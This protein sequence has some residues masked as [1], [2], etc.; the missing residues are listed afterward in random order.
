MHPQS[1]DYII[2]GGG[3]AGCATAGGLV[4]SDTGTVAVLEAG[5][6]DASPMV[7]TP[8]AL[9]FMM[10][11]TKR[12]WGLES[13][14]QEALGGRCVTVPRGKM[15]GGSGSINSMVWFRGRMDDFDRWNVPGWSAADVSPVFDK[16]EALMRPK[17]L[18]HPH[19]LAERFARVFSE[20]GELPPTPERES[21][22]IFHTNMRGSRRWSP[23]DAFLNPAKSS[24]RLTVKTRK[25]VARILFEGQRAIAVELIDGSKI[26]A[27][28]GI[29]LCAGAL[30]SPAILMRSG[31]GPAKDLYPLGID[32]LM[33]APQVGQNLHDHPAVG[34]HHAGPNSGYGLTLRQLPMWLLAPFAFML[35]GKG[36]FAS[37]IVEA[38][39]FFNARGENGPPDVQVHFIPYMM[40]WKGRNPVIG[41]GYFADVNVL[42]PKSRGTLK[43]LSADPASAPRIDL[44]VLSDPE[45]MNTLVAAFKRLREIL[46]I[47]PFSEMRAP[48]VY[49]A[50]NAVTDEQIRA[51]IRET[52]GTSYHPVG[53]LRMGEGEAP[54]SP[55]LRLKGMENLWIADASVMPRITSANIN[56]PCIMIG[57]RAGK[58]IPTR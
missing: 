49:P 27:R 21:S 38:G 7:R 2:V 4:E 6:S 23:A 43:L 51:Y 5:P 39:A 26:S 56:A 11:S 28:K 46:D 12:D 30:E 10:G 16:V 14:P 13:S 3:S 31:I 35:S 47:A 29:V 22:G 40:G 41:S 1:F 24:G 45:D 36:P 52:A 17:R 48:E 25:Q 9:M 33:D 57:Y 15:I 19:P 32:I 42:Q 18:P 58:I 53:T 20:H 54:V 55:Q 50:Q 34:L 8:F 37:N 44:G